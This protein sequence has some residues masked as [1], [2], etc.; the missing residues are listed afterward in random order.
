MYNT[1]VFTRTLVTKIKRNKGLILLVA[2]SLLVRLTIHTL[3]FNYDF[4]SFTVVAKLINGGKNIYAT[5]QRYNY[6]PIWFLLLGLFYKISLFFLNWEIVFRLL[7]ITTLIVADVVIAVFLYKNFGKIS[8]VWYL[9]NPLSMFITGFHNQF[10]NLAIAIGLVAVAM[11]KKHR[12]GSLLLLSVSLITKH[13][14][15][16]FPLW[17]F[18]RERRYKDKLLTLVPIFL[19]LISFV[20]FTTSI[21]AVNGVLKNVFFYSSRSMQIYSFLK[22]LGVFKTILYILLVSGVGFAFRKA[23]IKKYSLIYLLAFTAFLPVGANQ[24]FIIPL[25]SFAVFSQSIGLVYTAIALYATNTFIGFNFL[26]PVLLYLLCGFLLIK[27]WLRSNNKNLF[28]KLMNI[29]VRGLNKVVVL[30]VVFPL[31]ISVISKSI[32][33]GK[34]ELSQKSVLKVF[35]PTTKIFTDESNFQP[36]VKGVVVT[37]HITP[38]EN[39]LGAIY[40]P[41]RLNNPSGLSFFNNNNKYSISLVNINNTEVTNIR[42]LRNGLTQEGIVFATEPIQNSKGQ[43]LTLKIRA[44]INSTKDYFYIDRFGWVQIWYKF[45]Q[46][47]LLSNLKLMVKFIWLKVT[48]LVFFNKKSQN[49]LFA[50]T[51]LFFLYQMSILRKNKDKISN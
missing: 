7:I 42:T 17:L 40:I 20:P 45:P 51:L 28:K 6:G 39:Y 41:F 3:G 16:I 50:V 44:N 1:I 22:P 18:I 46:R 37:G 35:T 12:P 2:L 30:I 31:I 5:T 4:E 43:N 27:I 48:Y 21:S 14:F 36:L 10:D 25:P 24:Y 33:T 9:L 23:E 32:I 13:I 19:F 11:Y 8:A 49:I 38:K 47:Y 34:Q 15:F 29:K 26:I